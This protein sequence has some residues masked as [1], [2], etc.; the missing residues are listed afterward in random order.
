VFVHCSSDYQLYTVE[1]ACLFI[2]P[3]LSGRIDR[4]AS[5]TKVFVSGRRKSNC[6][7]KYATRL[8]RS[9]LVLSLAGERVYGQEGQ[10]FMQLNLVVCD[11]L[12]VFG[13]E[14]SSWY[15]V[16]VLYLGPETMMPVASALA[17]IIGAVIM[18]WQRLAQWVRKLI[19]YFKART[20]KTVRNRKTV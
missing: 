17:G 3:P 18:F 13:W 2:H 6:K 16:I 5:E 20:R 1:T 7:V 19:R 11:L 8:S 9:S 4:I 15:G 12:R 10:T 14:T